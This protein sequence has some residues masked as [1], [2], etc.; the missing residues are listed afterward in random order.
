[1]DNG[2]ELPC[3]KCNQPYSS[4]KHKHSGN[5]RQNPVKHEFEPYLEDVQKD[6]AKWK[7]I[8]LRLA[9]AIH[10]DGQRCHLDPSF[11]SDAVYKLAAKLLASTKKPSGSR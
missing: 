7:R 2:K 5:D 10:Q 6:A 9:R 11:M 1:M 3:A 8:A 4:P